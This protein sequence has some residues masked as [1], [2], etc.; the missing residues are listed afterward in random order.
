MLCS[1]A[2]YVKHSISIILEGHFTLDAAFK[3]YEDYRQY[4]GY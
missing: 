2:S 3:V 1:V 4:A